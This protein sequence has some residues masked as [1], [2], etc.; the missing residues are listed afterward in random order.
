MFFSSSFTGGGFVVPYV[1]ASITKSVHG[2]LQLGSPVS[3]AFGSFT[4]P[5]CWQVQRPLESLL[6]TPAQAV[7]EGWHV[8]CLVPAGL[9][10]VG[11][12]PKQM[13]TLSR[14]GLAFRALTGRPW[15]FSLSLTIFPHLLGRSRNPQ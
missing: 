11:L 10:G 8:E 15:T 9:L 3:S 2:S 4:L 6:V 5:A 1:L 14:E 7:P 12:W 13:P